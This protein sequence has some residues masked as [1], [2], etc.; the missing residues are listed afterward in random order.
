[1]EKKDFVFFGNVR[2][3]TKI[4]SACLSQ[5]DRHAFVIDGVYYRH[6][7]QFMMAAKALVF[8][9]DAAYN[10][11][12]DATSL[13]DMKRA[14]RAVV[15]YDDKRWCDSRFDVAMRGN[16][17]KFS[18]N[19][20]LKEYLLSTGDFVLV[21]AYPKDKLWGIGLDAESAAKIPEEN[22]P[23]QNLLGQALMRVR[24][25]LLHGEDKTPEVEKNKCQ[26]REI[27]DAASSQRNVKAML[28][29]L[30]APKKSGEREVPFVVNHANDPTPPTDKN[31]TAE[32]KYVSRQMNAPVVVCMDKKA[33]GS[34]NPLS[35]L[36]VEEKVVDAHEQA[37][38]D[39]FDRHYRGH[40][41]RQLLK[42][43]KNGG[44]YGFK[45]VK[46]NGEVVPVL[47]NLSGSDVFAAVWAKLFGVR[48][49]EKSRD[50]G[51]TLKSYFADFDFS[52][53]G[54]GKGA[55]RAYLNEV[56][57]TVFCEM[58]RSDLVPRKDIHG[59]V[60]HDERGKPILVPKYQLEE[61]DTKVRPQSIA[62][63][64]SPNDRSR[65]RLKL[66]IAFLAYYRLSQD[67][68]SCP[69]WFK[70]AAEAIFERREPVGDVKKAFVEKGKAPSSL[71]FDTELSRFRKKI[72]KLADKLM[73]NVLFA[74]EVDSARNGRALSPKKALNREWD[75]LARSVGGHRM[76]SIRDN[77][78][79]GILDL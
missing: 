7:A 51:R 27:E 32:L 19:G 25:K 65:A 1:M 67:K 68:N 39:K 52:Q 60:I 9:D 49:N 44:R 40:V 78:V 29:K 66:E 55:F 72:R 74:D 15:G 2:K 71:A 4:G 10:K 14:E 48:Y 35:G 36:A 50:D 76:N 57:Y 30:K 58:R 24:E 8:H 41:Y 11:I 54:V 17:A 13:V 53:E 61:D 64:V 33:K 38:L 43:I 20:E 77:V 31:F 59:R 75:E 3:D 46:Q 69:L 56:L 6:V 22:W 28:S 47:G 37:L 45:S 73:E 5:S 12:M 16:F 70:P 18:Q 23:G 26:L 62:P 21:A 34:W 42:P 79:R 63:H